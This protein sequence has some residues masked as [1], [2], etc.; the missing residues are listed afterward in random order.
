[1]EVVAIELVVALLTIALDIGLVSLDR[2]LYTGLEVCSWRSIVA[3]II[4]YWRQAKTTGELGVANG[5]WKWRQREEAALWR[6]GYGREGEAIQ[7][8]LA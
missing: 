3:A 1:M 8:C 7:G 4:S 2:A 6:Q 5:R